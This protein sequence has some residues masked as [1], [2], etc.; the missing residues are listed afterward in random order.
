M[1]PKLLGVKSLDN[2]YCTLLRTYSPKHFQAETA[3]G[4][5]HL[6]PQLANKNE[7]PVPGVHPVGQTWRDPGSHREVS[8]PDS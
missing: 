5:A 7:L 8:L 3:P 6:E 1:I 2:L 4:S